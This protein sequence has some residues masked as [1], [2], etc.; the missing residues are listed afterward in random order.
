MPGEPSTH[1]GLHNGKRK[2]NR[3]DRH[4]LM[5]MMRQRVA[6]RSADERGYSLIELLVVMILIGILA[7]IALAVFLNQADKGKDASAKSNVNNVVRLV[8]ACQAQNDTAEDF[9]NCDTPA[10]LPDS[11]MPIG[12]DAPDEV[13]SGDCAA[14]TS[15]DTI[16]GG[17]VRV[18]RSGPTCFVVFGV[19]NGGNRFWYIH[20]DD[21]QITRDCST[22]GVNGCPADG[23]WAG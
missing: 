15:S 17:S 12:S 16:T 4:H 21:G 19:S 10:E 14:P 8:Q 3:S 7:A 9:R 20:H 23:E 1:A 6:A 11:S 22:R 2:L 13:S 18:L 5:R